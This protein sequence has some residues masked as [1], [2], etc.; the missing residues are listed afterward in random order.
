MS[1]IPLPSAEELY[2]A[3]HREKKARK[4]SEKVLQTKTH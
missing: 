3:Y 4:K 2:F 1:H